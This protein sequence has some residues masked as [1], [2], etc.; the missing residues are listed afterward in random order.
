M[1]FFSQKYANIMQIVMFKVFESAKVK[2]QQNSHNFTVGHLT[3]TITVLFAVLWQN[4]EFFDFLSKFFAEIVC[5]TINCGN[6][7]LG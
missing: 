7:V 1:K 6:F 2:E 5:N 3:G 4:F